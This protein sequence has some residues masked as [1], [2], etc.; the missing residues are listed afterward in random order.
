MYEFISVDVL[1]KGSQSS[2]A[3]KLPSPAC[4][5]AC[6]ASAQTALMH[7]LF[8][9]QLV[10]IDL[11]EAS[12]SEKAGL[13]MLHHTIAHDVIKPIG[14]MPPAGFGRRTVSITRRG[15]GQ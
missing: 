11:F 3:T 9:P 5:S 4:C 8:W 1:V 2:S 14:R 12:Q 13:L 7:D 10:T 6:A 15:R